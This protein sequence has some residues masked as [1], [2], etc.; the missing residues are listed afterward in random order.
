M[1]LS[2]SSYGVLYLSLLVLLVTGII[3]GIIGSWWGKGWIWLSLILLIAIVAVMVRFG[4]RIYGEARKAVGLPFFDRGRTHPP[5]E[6]ASAEEI[7]TLLSQGNPM[8]LTLIGYGGIAI[9]AWLMLF[10][11]F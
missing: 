3:N 11:P 1:T 2:A 7:D 4:S 6:P 10:K 5:L 9:I 8:L